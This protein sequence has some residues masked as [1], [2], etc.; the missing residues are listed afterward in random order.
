SVKTITISNAPLA[1]ILS[2]SQNSFCFGDSGVISTSFVAGQSYQWYRNN[3]AISG[4]INASYAA[5][6][7]GLYKVVVTDNSSGCISS[8]AVIAMNVVNGAFATITY[9]GP[10]S[11]CSG[12]TLEL[13]ADTINGTNN[14]YQ[15]LKNGNPIIGETNF[16]YTVINSGNYQI[17]V[18][19]NACISTSPIKSISIEGAIDTTMTIV[20]SV[21]GCAGSTVTLSVP[22]NPQVSF[23]WYRNGSW[24]GNNS[25]TQVVTVSGSYYLEISSLQASCTVT[26]RTVVVNFAA[27][28]S[29]PQVQST[30]NAICDGDSI[31]ITTTNVDP[32]VNTYKWF[33]DGVLIPNATANNY[34]AKQAG[35]YTATTLNPSNC[36]ASSANS[37]T[38]SFY[39]NP[40]PILSANKPFACE[41]DSI[42]LSISNTQVL[43][44]IEWFN[45]NIT[46][47][48]ETK[49]SYI[50]KENGDYSCSVVD[51]NGCKGK[52][53]NTSLNF[54]PVPT[55]VISQNPS[56]RE[57]VSSIE[58]GNQWVYNGVK[59][60]NAK[61]PIYRPSTSGLY[62]TLVTSDRGC[63]G[64][65]NE[66]NISLLF[67]GINSIS[68]D[69]LT[70]SPNPSNG[71]FNFTL[72]SNL[73]ENS[74][75]KILDVQ[76]RVL[77]EANEIKDSKFD[78][79]NY[80]SGVYYF[81]LENNGQTRTI[82]LIKE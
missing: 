42:T 20:G 81:K 59:I 37:K 75:Y 55:P 40:S 65:S 69:D 35:V 18:T 70:I 23:K 66:L 46:I 15:W 33:K 52:T 72:S 41:G 48:G 2:V 56:N 10:T 49:T 71:V 50:A 27:P 74:R 19:K 62:Y 43:T 3:I 9:N 22:S 14:V 68:S 67:T 76:H 4:A 17:R 64:K 25:R 44:N 82:K 60:N 6:L 31:Q 47:A 7:G 29:V 78:L 36:A 54:Y 26:T 34:F 53:V 57:L 73:I 28:L 38:L 13:K 21:T 45:S 16:N 11:F 8:S 79:S 24:I 58:I 32:S 51:F 80:S 61:G 1:N 63:V 39:L 5:K 77:F 12:A 30:V